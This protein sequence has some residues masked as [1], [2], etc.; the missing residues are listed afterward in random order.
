MKLDLSDSQILLKDTVARLFSVESTMARVRAAEKTGGFD[1][2]L[3]NEIVAL[4]LPGMRAADSTEGGSSLLEAAL[5][6][7]QAGRHLLSAPLVEAIVATELLWRAGADPAL[8]TEAREGTLAVLALEPVRAGRTQV[9]PGG[10]AAGLILALEGAE[11]FAIRRVGEAAMPEAIAASPLAV[12]DLSEARAGERISI[13][14][15]AQART[16]FASAVEEWKLLSAALLA[17][18]AGRALEMAAAYSCERRQ[19]GKPI[20]A[21]QGIAHPLADSATDIDGARLLVWWAIWANAVARSDAALANAMACW[22]SRHAAEPAV[23]RAVHT[24]GGY[25][26]SLE[27]DIQ[28]YYR[29][30]MLVSQFAGEPH[31]D[32]DRIAE[33][34]LEGTRIPLPPAGEIGI[35]FAF[36]DQA[37]AYAAA[38][39]D[40]VQTNTTP[41]IEKK[42]HHSTSG[43][44]PGFHKLLA[45]AG[46]AFPDIAVDGR[47]ARSRY[48][49]LAAAPLWEDLHW[50]RV[51]SVTTEMVAKVAQRWSQPEAKREILSRILSGEALGALGFSEPASGSDIFAAKFGATRHGED[52]VMNGQKMFT[53]NAQN[54]DYIIMLARTNNQGKK[55]E[56]L[57]LFIM[58]LKLPGVEIH[59]VNTLMDE[60]TNIVYFTDVRVPDKYRLGEV[61]QGI[62]VMATVLQLEHGGADYHYLQS[63]TLRHA[64]AW[65]RRP[66]SDGTA[67]AGSADVRRA[68]ARAAINDAVSEVLC[69]RAVWGEVEGKSET[70]WG[71]MSKVFT[72]EALYRDASALLALASPHAAV[73]GIDRDL[74]MIELAMRRAIGMQIYGGTSEIHRSIIAEHALG[75]PSSRG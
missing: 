66:A 24:F 6:A 13:A 56:G 68:L 5:V 23:L 59:A 73:R 35:D 71:P 46:Y 65:A 74:D 28:L 33:R 42:K 69:R 40:F 32:L 14:R 51:P 25:G 72:T 61:D 1:R 70:A 63:A 53:T 47:A 4:G 12:L 19:F 34:L 37:E 9:I 15:G 29:R 16:A 10:A 36:G 17:G 55:I 8:V 45:Q 39:R 49:V 18:I 64:L 48:E 11:L 22:W 57:T 26:V 58:P 62:A 27:Y 52:W 21:F 75:M 43:H 67:P 60:R 3:W 30:A 44:H 50:T 38:L 2:A 54:A 41:E 31:A 20:G 7:E